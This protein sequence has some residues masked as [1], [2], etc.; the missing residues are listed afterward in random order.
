[1]KREI[2]LITLAVIGL[3]PGSPAPASDARPLGARPAA[4]LQQKED[5]VTEQSI[6]G[7]WLGVLDVGGTKLR[8]VLKIGFKEDNSLRATLD[9]PDQM[10]MNMRVDTI[11]LTGS[12]LRA[13]LNDLGA[14]YEGQVN[15]ERT[16]IAGQWKQ[17]PS[18]LPLTFKRF[19]E[20]PALSRPQEP[21]KPY[22]YAEEEVVYE[23]TQDK[24][25]LAATLTIPRGAGPHPAIVL[26]TGSGPEDRNET[27]FGHKP[28][29]ILADYLTRR[30]IAVLRADDRGV[31][32]S[33]PGAAT[34]TSES[35]ALDALSGLQF[36]KTRKEINPKQ[37]GLL[38]H[39]EGGMIVALASLR[40]T[41][42]AYIVML[43]GPGVPGDQLL[44]LQAALIL[45]ANGADEE[46]V[47]YNRRLQE[48]MIKILREEKADAAAERR[49]RTELPKVIAEIPEGKRKALGITDAAMEGQFRMMM[50]PW[51]RYF[52]V[53]DPRAVLKQVRCPVLAIGGERD[54]QV[55]PKQNLPAIN[56]ALRAGG[57]KDYLTVE[58]P[59]LNHLLQTSRT[60]SPAEYAQI[61]ETMSPKALELIADWIIKHT[62]PPTAAAGNAKQ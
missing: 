61:E 32:G 52:L 26:V 59:G 24:V 22:P 11:V 49:L 10:A 1:M 62:P 31:G 44:Y 13:E 28:F 17:G 43:A 50:T 51:F 15:S 20:L 47:G 16:E 19:T 56:E 45:K 37:I 36:L 35:Y 9:S 53:Y 25:K 4:T 38:G 48:L 30:G 2:F 3:I 58:L 40:S 46:L 54:L 8:L 41:D 60:G 12:T 34:D 33:S 5:K 55:P 18:A 21:Q 23:N 29:L 7:N 27:V 57:N 39:S 42:V 14:V 6:A